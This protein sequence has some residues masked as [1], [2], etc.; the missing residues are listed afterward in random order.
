MKA[1]GFNRHGNAEVI[2]RLDVADPVPED[3]EVLIRLHYTSVNRLDM[4][5]R[6]GVHGMKMDM[7]HMPGTDI[8]GTV[9]KC[10]NGAKKFNE[11]DLVISNTVYGCAICGKCLAEEENLCAQWKCMGLQVNGAY[12]EL[13]A[14]PERLLSR[15]PKMYSETE[16]AAMPHSLPVAWRALHTLGK[17]MEGETVLIRGASGNTGI[18]SVMLAKALGLKVMAMS[19]S[20]EKAQ[21]LKSLGA[22]HVLDT[23]ESADA[24]KDE[25]MSLTGGKGADIVIETSGSTLGDSV[26]LSAY[27][28][29]VITFGTIQGFVSEINIKRLYLWNVCVMGTHNAS[30]AEFDE[31]FGFASRN[32]IRPVIAETMP[33][34]Q[35]ADAQ[36]ALEQSR[37]FG[38]IVLKHW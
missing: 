27:S 2:E 24:I 23:N 8:V 3:N 37:Y 12:G 6:E 26:G 35:A 29:R 14:V 36:R 18:F 5:V 20:K 11:G 25:V 34:E 9:E 30:K 1:M 38:K 4:L 31:A 17:A 13:V 33:I 16:L 19:R 15:P 32:G 10:G 7:P 21:R 22:D 28:A